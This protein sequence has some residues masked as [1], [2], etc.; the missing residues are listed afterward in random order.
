VK[1]LIDR[2]LNEETATEAYYRFI[3]LDAQFVPAIICQMNDFRQLPVQQFALNSQAVYRPRVVADA[4]AVVLDEITG[5]SFGRIYNGGSERERKV[6]VWGWS[7]WL[8][9]SVGH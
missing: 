7:V 3:T 4:L 2:M 1:N 5:E 9:K 6:V 8:A